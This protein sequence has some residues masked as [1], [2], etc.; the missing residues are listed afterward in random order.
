MKKISSNERWFGVIGKN[1][2]VISLCRGDALAFFNVFQ[3]PQ[4]V[5]VS[6]RLFEQLLLRRCR[7]PLFETLDQ[8]VSAPFKKQPHIARGFRV[9]FVRR[10]PGYARPK[11]PLDVILQARPR[12]VARQIDRAGRN[13]EPLVNKM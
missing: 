12:M 13:Q 4:Q 5:A 9:A 11:A 10:E 1:V 6:G 3:C 8:I 2:G 7:H